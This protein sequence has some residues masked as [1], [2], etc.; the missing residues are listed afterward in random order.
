MYNVSLRFSNYYVVVDSDIYEKCG[1][2]T[3]LYTFYREHKG[4]PLF[5]SNIHVLI[6]TK[7][8]FCLIYRS[9]SRLL[10]VCLFVGINMCCCDCDRCNYQ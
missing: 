1:S 5:P 8:L 10:F 7:F 6:Y 2:S 3:N 9:R 4:S